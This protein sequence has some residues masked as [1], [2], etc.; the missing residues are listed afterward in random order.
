MNKVKIL[1]ILYYLNK[2]RIPIIIGAIAV[3]AL[4]GINIHAT[5]ADDGAPPNPEPI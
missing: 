2:Y 5:I 3:L 1:K 4:L